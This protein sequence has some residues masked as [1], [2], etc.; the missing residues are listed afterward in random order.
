MRSAQWILSPTSWRA[1]SRPLA[2]GRLRNASPAFLAAS[3]T[4]R[5]PQLDL[6]T[7]PHTPNSN[8]AQNGA[9]VLPDPAADLHWSNYRGG[10]FHHIPKEL[11]K[12]DSL[13]LFTKSSRP[14]LQ[15]TP[16][17]HVSSR[18]RVPIHPRD[19]L[20]TNKSMRAQISS[21]TTFSPMGVS[22]EMSSWS[23][24]TAG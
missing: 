4:H 8:M 12:I 10:K 19:L 14:T 15:D 3:F 16:R 2:L 6:A 20:P 5:P 7:S 1:G 24:P 17:D 21:L 22:V 9:S 11:A 23:T 13:Q 18:P